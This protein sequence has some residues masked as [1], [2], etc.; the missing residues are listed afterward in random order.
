MW[1][2]RSGSV[3]GPG[4]VTD[5]YPGRCTTEYTEVVGVTLVSSLEGRGSNDLS[6]PSTL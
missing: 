1:N 6:P 5:N 3:P 4:L 2:R